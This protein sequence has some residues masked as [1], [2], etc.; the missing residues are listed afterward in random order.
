MDLL[1]CICPASWSLEFEAQPKV[2]TALLTGD[3]LQSLKKYARQGKHVHQVQLPLML[4]LVGFT[5]RQ[6]ATGKREPLRIVLRWPQIFPKMWLFY[7]VSNIAHQSA[8]LVITV[9]AHEVRHCRKSKI[10][11]WLPVYVACNIQDSRLFF[12]L[13]NHISLS[14]QSPWPDS[15]LLMKLRGQSSAIPFP[16]ISWLLYFFQGLTVSFLRFEA[17]GKESGLHHLTAL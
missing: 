14:V 2:V 13:S 12:M 10:K 7:H 11:R 5:G 9:L 6:S 8:V 16:S 17:H 3:D 1:F 15:R 4:S